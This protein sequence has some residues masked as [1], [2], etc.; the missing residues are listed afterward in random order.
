MH[1]LY[2]TVSCD[3]LLVSDVSEKCHSL[4]PMFHSLDAHPSYTK[5]LLLRYDLPISPFSSVTVGFQLF[6]AI[7]YAIY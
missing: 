3:Q 4:L 2:I 1:F 5:H 7:L 6:S